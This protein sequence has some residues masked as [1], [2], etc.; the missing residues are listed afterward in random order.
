MKT[1]CPGD[2]PKGLSYTG[3]NPAGGPTK[4]EELLRKGPVERWKL[5]DREL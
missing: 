3:G 2:N 4:Q 1:S 5:S